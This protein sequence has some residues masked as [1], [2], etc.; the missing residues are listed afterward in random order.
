MAVNRIL[1]LRLSPLTHWHVGAVTE[2]SEGDPGAGAGAS[3]HTCHQLA[4]T[5]TTVT[6]A[7]EAV[8]RSA[9]WE[10]HDGWSVN[11]VSSKSP[12]FRRKHTCRDTGV[13]LHPPA[14]VWD[15]GRGARQIFDH[16]EKCQTR[17]GRFLRNVVPS[18][19]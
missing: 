7:A 9:G 13:R 17:T 2:A 5:V 16:F 14:P 8:A 10:N 12:E 6:G 15:R 4:A 11:Y 18:R 1:Q 19:F 3:G